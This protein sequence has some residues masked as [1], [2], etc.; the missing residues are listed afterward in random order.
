[1]SESSSL[2]PSDGLVHVLDGTVADQ[3]AA[4]EVVERPASAVKELV[5]NSLDAGA[6]RIE[7]TLLDGGLGL[8]EVADDGA[9]MGPG[10]AER[11]MQRH[12]TSKIASSA[13]LFHIG[14]FGF[15][16]EALP[17]IAS[18]SR[19]EL[20]TKPRDALGGTR[21][22]Y[23]GGERVEKGAAPAAAG[24]VVRVRD[25]FYNTPARLK[26]LKSTS[27]EMRHILQAIQRLSVPWPEVAFRVQH[28]RRVVLDLPA[29][30]DVGARF[31]QILG[32]D[33]AA[34]V[35]PVPTTSR[36]SVVVTGFAAEPGYTR[37][38]A[39]HVWAWV[40][41]RFVRDRSVQQAVRVGYEGML[42]RGR[43]PVTALFIEVPPAQVDVNVHPM[44]TEVRFHEQDLVFRAVRAAVRD[45]LIQT[46]WIQSGEVDGADPGGEGEA[47]AGSPTRVFTLT[48][49][50]A[51]DP[52]HAPVEPV[53]LPLL[54]TS[55]LA[56][57]A[58]G[59]A[60]GRSSQRG[61]TTEMEERVGDW[62]VGAREEDGAPSPE[63]GFFS[64]LNYIGVLH[65]SYLLAADEL[66]LVVVD[67]H[68]AHE[69]ITF[70]AL[71]AAWR[72]QRIPAQQLLVSEVIRLDAA[73]AAVLEEHVELMS[74]FGY[75]LEPFGGADFALTSVPA[76]LARGKHLDLIQDMIDELADAGTTDR[77]DKA[78]QDV[79]LRMA[80]HRSVRAGDVLREPEARALFRQMDEVP[81]G[82]HCP[83]GRP[84][85]FRLTLGEL[86]RRFGRS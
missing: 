16:G 67:Q 75:T 43:H 51:S 69:R 37:H 36:E 52:Q 71:R 82:G 86:E 77:A 58:D 30:T 41:R 20:V 66:G 29:T 22:L 26:F 46:P 74:S 73:R 1:M 76:L 14:S 44:K 84:V 24:T 68:A 10:D 3:I 9:G 12:A 49:P 40:N 25:L 54:H 83:H 17:S 50:T 33:A 78:V 13:D 4:G 18:V 32:H 85:W 56:T 2:S 53:N 81:H 48:R 31:A 27:V 38:T 21:L 15:R 11:A 34:K 55:R 42:D 61:W 23:E 64:R 72:T 65:D 63:G 80:C 79:L 28:Q 62:Q 70:E 19:L 5:E 60:A 6:R 45:M 8:I 39:D 59:R 47:V 35:H 7:V 57:G